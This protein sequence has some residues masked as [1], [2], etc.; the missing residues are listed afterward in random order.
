MKSLLRIVSVFSFFAVVASSLTAA[1]YL[2]IG[3]IKGESQ[4]RAHKQWIDVL[5]V[6]GLP[7]A[8]IRE[9]GSGMAT[10]KRQHK[11]ITI[12]KEIDKSTPLLAKAVQSQGAVKGKAAMAGMPMVL[13]EGGK[14]YVLKGA[15]VVSSTTKDGVETL[16]IEYES[17][18]VSM[19]EIK[20]VK[21]TK[22]APA[23]DHNSS[24]SNKTSH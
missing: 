7:E 19:A 13:S 16:V 5:S 22:A 17:C 14:T 1:G 20:S 10:G 6:S 11:P 24:R 23:T 21:A 12:I 2:K 9:K 8:S 3:D 4:D 18:E 15:H